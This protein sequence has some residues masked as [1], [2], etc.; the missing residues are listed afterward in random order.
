MSFSVSEKVEPSLWSLRAWEQALS[1][2]R[3]RTVATVE[4][5]CVAV[6]HWTLST[7]MGGPAMGITAI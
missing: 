6:Y 3:A 4:W 1:H 2:E 7:C 5:A